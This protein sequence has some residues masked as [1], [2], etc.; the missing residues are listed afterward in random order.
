MD[1]SSS[2][3]MDD[4]VFVTTRSTT[5]TDLVVSVRPCRSVVFSLVDRRAEL[6]PETVRIT[7]EALDA[8]D[9]VRVQM[10]R[11]EKP[12]RLVVQTSTGE[13]VDHA[14]LGGLSKQR[15]EADAN[16]VIEAYCTASSGEGLRVEADGFAPAWIP[17]P[18][19]G[20]TVDVVMRE[21][22]ELSFQIRGDPARVARARIGRGLLGVD[23]G[24]Q[25]DTV[26]CPALDHYP[27]RLVL[28]CVGHGLVDFLV[29]SDEPLVVSC[30]E[31]RPERRERTIDIRV[32]HSTPRGWSVGIGAIGTRIATDA[33][34][35]AA[36]DIPDDRPVVIS[37][38]SPP[39]QR[40]EAL[41]F[42]VIDPEDCLTSI[43]R[44]HRR[45]LDFPIPVVLDPPIGPSDEGSVHH[46]P[47][48]FSV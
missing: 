36:L 6:L 17:V 27:E 21:Q 10:D 40:P 39:T 45:Q 3:A 41:G 15:A 28:D 8:N 33:T 31:E 22:E 47:S 35:Q 48:L 11:P 26:V 44:T 42:A 24:L 14:R 7:A 34:G 2:N 29:S 19:P 16:G 20:E 5:Q 1:L 4:E 38:I 13:P 32:A 25:D 18:S 46:S 9:L 43:T 12:W 23:C 37:A 30:D